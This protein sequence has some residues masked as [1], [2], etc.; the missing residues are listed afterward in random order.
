MFIL[1]LKIYIPALHFSCFINSCSYLKQIYI[2][3]RTPVVG[4]KMYQY[5]IGNKII[6]L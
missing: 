5:K 2:Q 3:D 1:G 4:Y 6:T